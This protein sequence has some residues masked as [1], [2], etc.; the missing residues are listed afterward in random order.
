MARSRCVLLLF[1]AA[2]GLTGCST[3]GSNTE[4]LNFDL[5]Q[6]ASRASQLTQEG[7]RH[8]RSGHVKKA[9][10]V[11][12]R[13]IAADETYGPAHNNLGLLYFDQRDLYQAAWSFQRATEFMP[14]RAEP[15]NNLGLTYEAAGRLEEAIEMYHYAY[16]LDPTNPEYLGNLLR[17]R[18]IRGDRDES[19]RLGLQELLFID[20]RPDWI[21]WAEDQLVLV[22]DKEMLPADGNTDNQESE[23]APET[24]PIP[25]GTGRSISDE[26]DADNIEPPYELEMPSGGTRLQ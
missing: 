12:E 13:A 16:E 19:M 6:D 25:L 20:T 24:L 11:F 15:L 22:L 4:I 23:G 17:A 14:E 21:D 9:E 1:L 8:Y 3:F 5:G 18:V 2:C 7:A 10:A 26:P